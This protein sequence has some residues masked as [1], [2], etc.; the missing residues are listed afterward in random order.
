MAHTLDLAYYSFLNSCLFN[1][2]NLAS[3]DLF[4]YTQKAF[5]ASFRGKGDTPALFS[6]IHKMVTR[7]PGDPIGGLM[8]RRPADIN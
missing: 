3:T 2:R 7:S 4:H 6:K 5:W 1:A 8:F